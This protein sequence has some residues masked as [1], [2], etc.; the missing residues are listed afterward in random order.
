MVKRFGDIAGSGG[1]G[2]GGRGCASRN[3]AWQRSGLL[4][5]PLEH[6]VDGGRATLYRNSALRAVI[7]DHRR[8]A[9][10]ASTLT[11]VAADIAALRTAIEAFAARVRS[12]EE[13]IRQPKQEKRPSRSRAQ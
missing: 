8:N 11:G 7:N 12:H 9:A 2:N 5:H 4:V 13:Q 6:P 3:G 1:H 10:S